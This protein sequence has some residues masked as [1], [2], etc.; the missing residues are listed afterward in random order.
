[1]S[2]QYKYKLEAGSKHTICPNCQ[3]KTFK[4]YVRTGTNIVVDSERFQKKNK[5]EKK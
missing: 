3:K 4:P 1:M 2:K 5:Y